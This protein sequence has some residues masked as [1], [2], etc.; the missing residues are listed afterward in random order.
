MAGMVEAKNG[1]A[2]RMQCWCL[3]NSI[4][5]FPMICM[6]CDALSVVPKQQAALDK[7]HAKYPSIKPADPRLM[8][9]PQGFIFTGPALAT[10]APVVAQAMERQDPQ[11]LLAK[12]KSMLDQGLITQSDYETKK[13]DVLSNL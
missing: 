12:L 1:Y 11:E 8:L 7:F 13:A 5:L 2:S 4:F 9:M 10:P 3:L 6:V